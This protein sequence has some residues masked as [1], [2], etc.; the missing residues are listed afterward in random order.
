ME[1][2]YIHNT[3]IHNTKAA[4]IIVP[5]ILGKYKIQSIV[6]VGCG[7]GTWLAIFENY[8]VEYIG[9]DG[10]YVDRSLLCIKENNFKC[11]DLNNKFSLERK[12]D[13]A[14]CLEVVEHLEVKSA[15]SF[16]ECLCSLSDLIIFSAAIPCQGGQNHLNE[17]FPDY[18]LSIFESIGYYLVDDIK[19]DIWGNPEIEWWYQQN[20]MILK[21]TNNKER[22][23]LSFAIHPELYKLKIA[24]IRK[25]DTNYQKIIKGDISVFSAFKILVKTLINFLKISN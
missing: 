21:K 10:D 2:K 25:L 24:E 4:E 22:R 19:A 9:I 8:G 7:I 15:T 5:L 12:Y 3:L 1:V 6:D 13:L 11:F 23:R 17:Q 16:I 14:L 18:W 20:I